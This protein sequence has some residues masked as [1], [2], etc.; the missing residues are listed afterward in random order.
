MEV[1]Q[2][3]EELAQTRTAMISSLWLRDARDR[4]KIE[5]SPYLKD[6]MLVFGSW[7]S[8]TSRGCRILLQAREWFIVQSDVL[9]QVQISWSN[10]VVFC[11]PRES[12]KEYL[13]FGLKAEDLRPDYWKDPVPGMRGMLRASGMEAGLLKFDPS[14]DVCSK[15][16]E[17][18][19]NLGRSQCWCILEWARMY[20]EKFKAFF[21][22]MSRDVE[23]RLYYKM[24]YDCMRLSFRRIFDVTAPRVA[25][26]EIGMNQAVF[27][28]LAQETRLLEKSVEWLT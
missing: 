16:G 25:R 5:T 10:R 17:Q 7:L 27:N 4:M 6:W 3:A 22:R 9:F 28:T 13:R 2:V 11:P 12:D 18:C 15:I 8:V 19:S 21:S 20:P 26:V 14:V 24:I 1:C 23:F